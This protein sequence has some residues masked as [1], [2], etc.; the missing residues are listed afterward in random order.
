V[1][2]ALSPGSEPG[3]EPTP[4]SVR[5][6]TTVTGSNDAEARSLGALIMRRLDGDEAGLPTKSVRDEF[7]KFRFQEQLLKYDK[8]SVLHGRLNGLFKASVVGLGALISGAAASTWF[9]EQTAGQALLVAAAVAVAVIG[10]VDQILKPAVRNANYSQCMTT[11]RRE[12]WDLSIAEGATS[13]AP[14]RTGI[15]AL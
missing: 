2:F 11:L 8:R 4:T 15:S 14:R 6:D 5:G 9:R 1:K 12:G 7:V 3:D 10:A 13:L